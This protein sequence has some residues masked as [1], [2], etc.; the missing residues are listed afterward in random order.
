PTPPPRPEPSVP[1]LPE[2]SNPALLDPSLANEAAPAEYKVKFETSKGNFVVAVHRDWAPLGA[3]RFYNLVKIGFFDQAKFFRVVEG[4]MVQF[5]MSPNP[6]VMQRWS[7]A[8]IQDDPVK[9]GNKPGRITFA[10]S[11]PNSRST[12]VFINYGDNS[13]KEGD[14]GKNLDDM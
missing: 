7:N 6:A 14:N 3:D 13:R 1:S 4:F 8:N 2:G 9:E 12:Q 11:G 10:T 5:G